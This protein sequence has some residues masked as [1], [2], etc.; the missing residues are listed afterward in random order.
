[1]FKKAT[2]KF[3]WLNFGLAADKIE[4]FVVFFDWSVKKSSN[5][6]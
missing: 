6:K 1:M 2:K 4:I 5:E 3:G